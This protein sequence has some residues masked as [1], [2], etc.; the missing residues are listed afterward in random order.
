MS[1]FTDKALWTVENLQSLDRYFVQNLDMGEGNYIQKLREQLRPTAPVVKQL[2]AEMNWFMLLCPSNISPGK[3]REVISEIWRWSGEVEPSSELLGD[4]TLR[5]IGSAG[6]AFNTQRWRE[7]VFFI[8]TMLAFKQLDLAERESWLADPWRF[9]AALEGIPDGDARQLRHMM[10]FLLFPDEFERIFARGDR[11][12][13]ASAFSGEPMRDI[14]RLTPI[15]L[16]RKLRGIRAALEKEYGTHELDFYVTPLRERWERPAE[17]AMRAQA[18]AA[19]RSNMEI[20][21]L[22]DKAEGYTVSQNEDYS[23]DSLTEGLFI[24]PSDFSRIVERLRDKKNLIL[25]GP[26][27]VGKTFFARRLAYALMGGRARERVRMV[28]FHPSYSYEDFVRG[29]RP[30]GNGFD[31]CD[32]P[33]HEFCVEAQKDLD[34]DYVFIVDEINRANLGKVFGELM[35]L[36]E[37]DKRDEEWAVPLAYRREGDKPF[38]VPPNVYLLGLMNTADRSL[39]MVDYALRR[40]FA[41]IDVEAGFSTPQFASFLKQRNAS[42]ALIH[43]IVRDMSEL[44]HEIAGDRANLGPGFC[45][46]HSYFCT[47][48]SEVGATPEWYKE[49]VRSE[50]MPLLR[51]YWFDDLPKTKNWER[52]LLGE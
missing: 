10:L 6:T 26:P 33:F 19:T 1:V 49:V 16:D 20:L 8:K 44:N 22:M 40:R 7:L 39:A 41:F 48:M 32:G 34:Q 28:Q 2:A 5:G 25:Q 30:N 23:L 43:Q 21:A 47:G 12:V 17:A 36:I 45:I 31:L 14:R 18:E 35:M 50:I 24:D 13:I 51:E 38:F 27:G 29:Y 3:K 42:D 4:A 11:Q 9:G 52:R 15:E 37:T 46:G